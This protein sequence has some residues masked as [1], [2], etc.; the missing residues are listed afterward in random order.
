MEF[1]N[2]VYV[3]DSNAGVCVLPFDSCQRGLIQ[4]MPM[5]SWELETKVVPR[6]RQAGVKKLGVLQR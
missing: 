1:V 2:V 6:K 5:I 4:W 3:V